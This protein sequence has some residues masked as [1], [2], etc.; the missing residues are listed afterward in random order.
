VPGS[1]SPD[2]TRIHLDPV[3]GLAGDMFIAAMLD[4]WP[5]RETAMV[6]A[7]QAAG[8]PTGI[9]LELLPHTDHAL[10]GRRFVVTNGAPIDA[11]STTP[12]RTIRE[13]LSAADMPGATA[14]RATDIFARLAAAEASVHGVAI[15]DVTFHEVGAWDSIADIVGA[16]FLIDTCGAVR[17]TAAALPLGSGR[18]ASAHG[19]LP[20][21]AP[22]TAALLEGFMTIEDGIGGERITPTGAAII[23]H[24]APDQTITQPAAWLL[25]SGTGFGTKRLPG[26]S[27]I[28]R[29][30]AYNE[31]AGA[32][33]SDQVA[34]IRFEIDDQSPED[35]AVALDHLRATR[36]VL[37][38]IQSAALGK[39]GRMAAQVQVLCATE[40]RE[41]AITACLNETTTLGVRWEVTNR[42][43][44]AR[45]MHTISDVGGT[46]VKLTQRPDGR[47]TVKAEMDDLANA[48]DHHARARRRTMAEGRAATGE[49]ANENAGDP[50]GNDDV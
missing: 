13:R 8:L 4:A 21:P 28:L 42:T 35:L 22:A 19:D 18:V 39:K 12:W 44:L 30:L 40:A 33:A 25:H 23:A 48:G 31:E 14:A 41:A 43:T 2:A 37:D 15:D 20:V 1:T 6:G 32:L 38:V 45:D 24:L 49:A 34:V 7:I 10:S 5:E 9:A 36:G 50:P 29:V 17:W 3:G 46:R 47:T 16:A 27:N 11:H 26:I